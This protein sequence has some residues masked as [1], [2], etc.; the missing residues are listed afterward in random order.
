MKYNNIAYSF[1]R[2]NE[3]YINGK[4]HYDVYAQEH[5]AK[6]IDINIKTHLHKMFICKEKNYNMF[7]LFDYNSG[8]LIRR[9]E[10]LKDL[11]KSLEDQDFLELIAKHS[12]T[13]SYFNYANR[14][15]QMIKEKHI[16]KA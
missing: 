2:T 6:I 14:L 9:Y 1:Y 15:Q 10:K 16:Y 13:P 3:Q 11:Y 8:L 4:Y 7:S 12:N 5:K